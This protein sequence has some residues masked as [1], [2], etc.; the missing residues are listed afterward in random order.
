M[1]AVDPVGL[2]AADL[3]AI[4][5]HDR[6]LTPAAYVRVLLDVY[7][8]GRTYESPGLPGAYPSLNDVNEALAAALIDTSA[9]VRIFQTPALS[10]PPR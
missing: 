4:T 1:T 6:H 2:H 7:E 3:A 10:R 8:W 9:D 5:L